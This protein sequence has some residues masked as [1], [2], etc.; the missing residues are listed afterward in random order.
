MLF[1]S[2]FSSGSL[3]CKVS[4]FLGCF[5][6]SLRWIRYFPKVHWTGRVCFAYGYLIF[7]KFDSLSWDDLVA[8][9]WKFSNSF[10]YLSF[11]AVNAG[12]VLCDVGVNSISWW[13]I[14]PKNFF[15]QNFT[16]F[17]LFYSTYFSMV[18][19]FSKN[20]FAS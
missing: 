12:K 11:D 6:H 17:R 9:L 19:S 10:L 7:W 14:F 13:T 15:F 20:F 18:N 4:W 1:L 8:N 2:W 5:V 16:F 3:S